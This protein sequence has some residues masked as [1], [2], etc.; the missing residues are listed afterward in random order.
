MT[1]QAT[2]RDVPDVIRGTPVA[3]I[4]AGLDANELCP[5]GAHPQCDLIWRTIALAMAV[6]DVATRVHAGL[7]HRKLQEGSV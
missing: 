3:P 5:R 1:A 4:P 7:T 6:F 2:L